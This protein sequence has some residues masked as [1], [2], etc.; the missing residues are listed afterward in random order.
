MRLRLVIFVLAA[1]IVVSGA[2]Q[3][4]LERRA[5]VKRRVRGFVAKAD[6]FIKDMKIR[7]AQAMT[8]RVK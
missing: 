4:M 2:A 1:F 8:L 3:S 5:E 7:T 6:V